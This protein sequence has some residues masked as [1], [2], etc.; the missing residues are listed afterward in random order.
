MPGR[1]LDADLTAALQ[2]AA[3]EY[4]DINPVDVSVG[5]SSHADLLDYV[6]AR[7]ESGTTMKKLAAE[8]S[9]DSKRDITY[10]K[11]VRFLMSRYDEARV[12]QALDVARSRASHCYVED[13]LSIV[14]APAYDSVSV[15]QARAKANQRNWMASRYNPKAYG[16]QQGAQVSVQL[17]VS[18]LHLEALQRIEASTVPQA[19]VAQGDSH[20][21][22]AGEAVAPT[23]TSPN[24]LSNSLTVHPSPDRTE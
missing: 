9:E 19:Q 6:M 5:L 21:L 22:P 1:S 18:T 3:N 11:L 4:H 10:S 8:L 24:Q 20:A 23:D 13:A 15:Q 7:I 14:D 2:A 12:N 16:S 17:N